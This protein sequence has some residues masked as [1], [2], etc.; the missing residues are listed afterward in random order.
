MFGEILGKG[1][2]LKDLPNCVPPMYCKLSEIEFRIIRNK[3]LNLDIFVFIK[4]TK[5]IIHKHPINDKI[6]GEALQS[7]Q[8]IAKK[9]DYVGTIAIEYFINKNNVLLVNEISPRPHNSAH[10]TINAFNVSQ[11]EGHVRAVCD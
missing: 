9:L 8:K 5:G 7:A 4:K 1:L 2:Y 10:L 6:M 3:M 11:F